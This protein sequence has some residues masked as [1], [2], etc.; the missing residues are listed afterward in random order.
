MNGEMDRL[1][2]RMRQRREA[3]ERDLLTSRAPRRGSAND[4]R[5]DHPV[6]ARVFDP[7][8]GQ[9]GEVIGAGSENIVVPAPKR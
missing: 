5:V 2:E 9:E 3:I 8:S 6:G 4:A 1:L 7:L